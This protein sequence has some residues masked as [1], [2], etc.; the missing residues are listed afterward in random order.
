MLHRIDAAVRYRAIHPNDPV[1]PPSEILL[2]F[3]KPSQELVEK[4]KK[5]L[6]RL[7][8]AADVKKGW[9][10]ILDSKLSCPIIMIIY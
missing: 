3:S 8:A 2:K 5:Y 1:P 10:I 9:L 6:E 7:T 4:S